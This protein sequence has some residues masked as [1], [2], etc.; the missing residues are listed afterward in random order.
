MNEKKIRLHYLDGLRGLAALYVVIFHIYRYL[1]DS[2]PGILSIPAKVLRYGNFA[3]IV[4][5]VLSGYC[6]MLPIARSQSYQIN[7]TLGNYLQRRIKRI[8]PPY[9][10]ALIFSLILVFIFA[11]L[12]S[13]GIFHWKNSLD[14]GEFSPFITSK[15]VVTHFLLIHNISTDTLG[16]INAP[17]WTVA[18]EWQ[19]YFL[20]P[21]VLLPVWRYFGFFKFSL[22]T[23]LISVIP[24][25]LFPHVVD[26]LHSWYIGL[27]ALGMIA[28]NI[29]FSQQEK[30]IKFRNYLNYPV[31]IITFSLLGIISEWKKF[32]LH[33]WVNN[34]FIGLA[35][36]CLLVYCTARITAGKKPNLTLKVLESPFATKLG[37]F[38]YSLYLTHGPIITIVGNI[39]L[40][41]KLPPLEFAFA[42]Y[43]MALPL[44]LTFAYLF[45]WFFERPFM[46]GTPRKQISIPLGK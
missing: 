24:V 45:Y 27:F 15:D 28:A 5:I 38:S 13:L 3:V 19:I 12:N 9:Y 23:F 40:S 41:E 6:L 4:F 37:K 26:P 33:N 36:A 20:F 34:G 1:G 42:I 17:M 8:L 2:L 25:Y 32:G 35:T 39:L 11:E 21:L 31:L 30:A 18:V 46:S 16:S 44:S 29:G 43:L 10:A 14:Y 22:F 7:G